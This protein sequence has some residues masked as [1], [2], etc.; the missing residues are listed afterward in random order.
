MAESAVWLVHLAATLFLT[1]LI[2]TVQVVHYPLFKRVGI[3]GFAAYAHEHAARIGGVVGPAML[4]EGT[5]AVAL[6]WVRPAAVPAWAA[7][8][9]VALLL[10]NWVST[11]VVQMPCH[12][13]LAE[14]F[15]PATAR[16]LV[17]SNWVRTAAWTLRAAGCVWATGLLI[18]ADGA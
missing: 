9:G 10:V 16:W 8:A 3:A 11:A 1:G 5:T 18:R 12:A 15:D 6:L 7:W 2:W 4:L 17:L 14:G 13:R